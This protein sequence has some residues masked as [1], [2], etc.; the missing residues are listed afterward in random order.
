MKRIMALIMIVIFSLNFAGCKTKNSNVVSQAANAETKDENDIGKNTGI[1]DIKSFKI[2]S[3]NQLVILGLNSSK[4]K[5]FGIYDENGK[6]V[7]E[8]NM[9]FGKKLGIFTIDTKDNIYALSED[10]GKRHITV[11]DASGEK[12]KTI[13]LE[14]QA[15]SSDNG[16]EMDEEEDTLD[17]SMTMDSKG[18]FFILMFDNKSSIEMVDNDGKSIKNIYNRCQFIN[19]DGQ[20]NLLLGRSDGDN[21]S[22]NYY[23]EKLNP[24]SGQSIWKNKTSIY[25]SFRKVI[26]RNGD[27]EFYGMDSDGLSKYNGS[28]GKFI[29]RTMNFDEYGLVD[30]NTRIRSIDLNSNKDAYVLNFKFDRESRT[31]TTELLKFN[32]NS[33]GNNDKKVITFSTMY[34]GGFIDVAISKFQKLHPDIKIEVKDVIDDFNDPSSNEKYIKSVNTEM[35]AGKGSDIIA[36]NNLP[37]KKYA[38]K[39]MLVNLSELIANDKEFNIKDYNENVINAFKYKDSLYAMPIDYEFLALAVNKKLLSAENLNID[40]KN[41]T[42]QDMISISQKVTKD[43]NGDGKVDQYAFPKMTGSEIM[44]YL[45]LRNNYS[46]FIDEGKKQAKFDSKEFIDILNLAK[47]FSTK[48]IMDAKDGG[49]GVTGGGGIQSLFGDTVFI[50]TTIF[51]C[52]LLGD[53]YDLK[54][55][56]NNDNKGISF[57]S[58]NTFSIN[59]NT[60]YKNESWQF[61]KLLLSEEMQTGDGIGFPINKSALDK[62]EKLAVKNT[63]KNK[64]GYILSQDDIN[65]LNTFLNNVQSKEN[66][67]NV[68]INKII[69]DETNKFIKGQ[70]SAEQT[71]KTIQ[72]KVT[73]MI[74]E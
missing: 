9:D 41:W 58:E 1:D 70:Q 49:M 8:I 14:K 34:K 42:L 31:E 22:D 54:N 4:E 71:A 53:K 11:F 52:V 13:D 25:K 19:S 5:K 21:S 72:S 59:K 66:D 15:A 68:E 28:D 3:K 20:D 2:N 63:A 44:E 61:L 74:N 73:T 51:N 37:Y 29:E 10:G 46:K 40:D 12:T 45:L 50:P 23:I 69:G 26:C 27:K 7:K 62:V 35:M 48:N 17:G 64:A 38:D 67:D 18:N 30:F 33:K 60:K 56:P 24:V 36:M 57:K 65:T 39:N 6:L 32:L 16:E 47:D 55:L 43:K